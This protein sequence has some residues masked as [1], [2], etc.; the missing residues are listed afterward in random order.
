MGREDPKELK[1]YAG[2]KAVYGWLIKYAEKFNLRAAELKEFGL[3]KAP[4]SW[5]YYRGEVLP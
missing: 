4:Q 3:E 2:K 1:K 5:I